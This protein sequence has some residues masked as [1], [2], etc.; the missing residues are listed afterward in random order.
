M[1]LRV[2]HVGYAVPSMESVRA[3]FESL[4]WRVCGEVTDDASRKVRIQFMRLGEETVEL[5]APLTDDSP[6]RNTLQK[7]CGAPYHV[8]YEAESLAEAERELKAMRFIVFRKAAPAPAIGGCRVEWFFARN[9]GI[10]E[11][12]EKESQTR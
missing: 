9:N 5:V 8:C 10:I 2:H 7:G 6:I 12:V 4:G 11:V 1:K 3:E